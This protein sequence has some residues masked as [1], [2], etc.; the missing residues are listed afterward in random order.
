MSP[1]V[2]E[3][4]GAA[5]I[6]GDYVYS[7]KPNPAMLA[8]LE[9]SDKEVRGHLQ[10]TVDVCARHGCPLE[11]ILKDIST[12]KYE[13]QRLWRWADIAMDVVGA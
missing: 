13:P 3:E 7:R 9:F 4:V 10:A 1:W 6:K 5:E 12:V 11:L 2:N 8:A